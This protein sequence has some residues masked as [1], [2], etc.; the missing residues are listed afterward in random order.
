MPPTNN[1]VQVYP[2]PLALKYLG[3]E[4]GCVGPVLNRAIEVFADLIARATRDNEKQFTRAEWGFIAEGF[5]DPAKSVTPISARQ[6]LAINLRDS[7]NLRQAGDKWFD[8]DA[9]ERVTQICKHIMAM[10][11]LHAQAIVWS[12]AWKQSH[13]T[14]EWWTLAA[15]M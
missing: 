15:R 13:H 11:E 12:I 1:R 9:V 8:G 7:Q 10:D 6:R 3:A 5:G 4:P 14:V 2:D